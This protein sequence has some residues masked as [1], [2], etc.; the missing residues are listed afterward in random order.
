MYVCVCQRAAR[1]KS[2][3]ESYIKGACTLG[4]AAPLKFVFFVFGFECLPN[5]LDFSGFSVFFFFTLSGG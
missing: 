1:Q 3:F 5:F 4:E 2:E